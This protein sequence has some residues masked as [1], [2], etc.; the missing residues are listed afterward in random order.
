[1]QRGEKLHEQTEINNM[2]MEKS[3]IKIIKELNRQYRG[4]ISYY[5]NHIRLNELIISSYYKFK[6]NY[7]NLNNI[8]TIIKNCD[9]NKIIEPFN[10]IENR[11]II[12][13]EDNANLK[14]FMNELYR[15]ELKEDDNK[16]EINNKYFNNH[17]SNPLW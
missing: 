1:M 10:E 15:I 3:D 7:Y 6:N 2:I 5:E 11:A 8:K 14:T 16:I 13:G 9:R 4:L 17:D 12:P